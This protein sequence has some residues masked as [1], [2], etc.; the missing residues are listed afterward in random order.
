M[1]KIDWQ[2]QYWY[3]TA[4]ESRGFEIISGQL[5][6]KVLQKTLEDFKRLIYP[7]E[8]YENQELAEQGFRNLRLT[9]FG[10]VYYVGY[11]ETEAYGSQ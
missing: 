9:R 8:P 11:W 1:F 2:K 6:F 7:I 4:K 3:K 5:C 10:Q